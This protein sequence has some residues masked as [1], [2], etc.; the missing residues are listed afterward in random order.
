M[1]EAV[2]ENETALGEKQ[3]SRAKMRTLGSHSNGDK[4]NRSEGFKGESKECL[5]KPK[6]ERS[7]DLWETGMKNLGMRNQTL[8][9]L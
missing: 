6:G 2:G 4:E 3:P 7:Q 5:K 8:I 1:G 9:V